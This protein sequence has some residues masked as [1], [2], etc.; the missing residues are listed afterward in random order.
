LPTTLWV[1][2]E[3]AAR[4]LDAVS[5]AAFLFHPHDGVDSPTTTRVRRE[6]TIEYGESKNRL[7]F[8]KLWVVRRVV[9][10]VSD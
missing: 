9:R 4:Q 1:F 3:W 2:K 6:H 7:Y 8:S 5:L 10:S